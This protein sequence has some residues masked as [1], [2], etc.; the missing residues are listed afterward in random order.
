MFF[1]LHSL[2]MLSQVRYLSISTKVI[3]TV[4]HSAPPPPRLSIH[5]T[6]SNVGIGIWM[7]HK[8]ITGS[9]LISLSFKTCIPLYLLQ[10][11]LHPSQPDFYWCSE[12]SYLPAWETQLGTFLLIPSLVTLCWQLVICFHG[13]IYTMEIG[14]SYNSAHW[15]F[16][17]IRESVHQHIS[18]WEYPPW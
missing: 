8:Q 3:I 18:V 15:V 11:S 12:T 2:Q 7:S 5:S 13:N 16:V 9:Q 10:F 14:R 17:L 4:G 6:A 1:R